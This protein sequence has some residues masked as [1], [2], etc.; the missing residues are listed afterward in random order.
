MQGIIKFLSFLNENWTSILVLI[1]VLVG[2][3][4]K[5]GALKSKSKEELYQAAQEQIKQYALYLVN[6]AEA[7]FAETSQAGAVKRAEVISAIYKDYPILKQISDQE[8]VTNFID[9]TIDNALD[10]LS[11]ICEGKAE[12]YI[13]ESTTTN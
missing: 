3:I 5:V 12:N 2:L 8:Q 10:N 9:E 13:P 1:G 4:Q 11:A 6:K 7:E